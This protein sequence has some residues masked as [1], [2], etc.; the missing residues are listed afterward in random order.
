MLAAKKKLERMKSDNAG[1]ELSSDY[2]GL[3]DDDLSSLAKKH[4][5]NEKTSDS[6]IQQCIFNECILQ[7]RKAKAR[8]KHLSG[9]L[10]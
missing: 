5:T 9:I 7:A 10:F 1:G 6:D 4:F 2:L 8:G 3:F